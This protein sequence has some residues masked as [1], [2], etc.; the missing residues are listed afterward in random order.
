MHNMHVNCARTIIYYGCHAFDPGIGHACPVV[1][2]ALHTHSPPFS[3][4]RAL[5]LHIHLTYRR[6]FSHGILKG[7][8]VFKSQ[9][10]LNLGYWRRA[11]AK[12]TATRIRCGFG[13][14]DPRCVR[15]RRLGHRGKGTRWLQSGSHRMCGVAE[16]RG[17]HRHVSRVSELVDSFSRL[18][19]IN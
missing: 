17:Q 13:C 14:K 5:E 6:G 8:I 18:A 15:C 11:F 10:C 4:S 9:T 7:G 1:P 2:M 3:S 16:T 19:K 12:L